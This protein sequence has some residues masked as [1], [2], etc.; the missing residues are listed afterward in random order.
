MTIKKSDIK[1]MQ[2]Q[3]MTDTSDGGGA[4]TGNEVLPDAHNTFFADISD[5][6]RAYGAVNMSKGFMQVTSDDADEYLGANM[7]LLANVT[8]PTVN[9]TLMTTGD[10]YDERKDAQNKIESYLTKSIKFNGMLLST[11]LEG[12]RVITLHTRTTEVE[13]DINSV[14]CLIQDENKATEF[15]QYVRLTKIT[16]EIREFTTLRGGEPYKFQ[17]AV[18]TCEISEP[19]AF[20]FDGSEATDIDG[21]Q[22]DTVVRETVV[23]NATN[24]YSSKGLENDA[25]VGELS[26]KVDGLYSQLV[27]SSR[28][29]I[30]MPDVYVNTMVNTF[31][32]GD[33]YLEFTSTT[34]FGKNTTLIVGWFTPSTLTI[35]SAI[36]DENG[37]LLYGDQI[38]GTVDYTSGTIYCGG[39]FPL[40]GN[41]KIRLKRAAPSVNAG[42][43]DSTEITAENQS[44][45][46]IKTFDTAP[47]QGS[48]KVDFMIG[49]KWYT[50]FD[51][52][53]GVLGNPELG[54][55]IINRETATLTLTLPALPDVGSSI[56]YSWGSD[57]STLYDQEA[58]TED[59]IQKM[60]GSIEYKTE[61]VHDSIE[62]HVDGVVI[63]GENGNGEIVKTPYGY[64]AQPNVIPK[65]ATQIR[66]KATSTETR[67]KSVK[68]STTDLEPLA[69]S[70]KVFVSAVS[71]GTGIIDLGRPN[72]ENHNIAIQY[73][74]TKQRLEAMIRNDEVFLGGEKIGSVG[75]NPLRI[76]LTP[77]VTTSIK[78]VTYK[79]W[80]D[81][82]GWFQSSKWKL[83]GTTTTERE[84]TLSVDSISFNYTS[85]P[86]N[87]V[88]V[89]F[90]FEKL[91][92]PLQIPTNGRFADG[93]TFSFGEQT[94][95][96]NGKTNE[97]DR[98]YSGVTTPAGYYST[99]KQR[100]E[101]TEWVEGAYRPENVSG[102][103]FFMA[104]IPT[105]QKVTYFTWR[106]PFAPIV[107]Q[108]LIINIPEIGI[109]TSDAQGK[110]SGNSVTGKVDY[111]RGVVQIITKGSMLV[112][113]GAANAVFF[114]A[115]KA[116]YS[117]VAYSFL[118][119]DS[120]I[121][122]IN[123]VRLPPDGRVPVYKKG[124][125]VLIH[126]TETEPQTGLAANTTINAVVRCG[127]IYLTNSDGDTID[128][129]LYS[130]DLDAGTLT[131]KSSFITQNCNLVY[132]F[133]DLALIVDLD[134]S[135]ILRLARPVSHNYTAGKATVSGVLIADTMGSRV[136]NLFEQYTWDSEWQ[137][138]PLGE[139]TNATFNDADYPLLVTNKG[140][141]T[142]RWALVFT[143]A[144]TFKVIG[145][146]VGQIAIGNTNETC[147]PI[148]PNTSVPYFT[149][150][151][152]G[153]GLGWAAGN[154]LRFNT[155]GAQFPFWLIRTIMQSDSTVTYD[156]FSLALRGNINREA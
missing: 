33:E 101:I 121:I 64:L 127:D 133:E 150:N 69:G 74:E 119:L 44:Y 83:N 118:P 16:R 66:V 105:P 49:G 54:T 113:N 35:D 91:I 30:A 50:I 8:D 92:I 24:Y 31:I 106:T 10:N 17:R 141:L 3:R 67:F 149:I 39:S 116:T 53:N 128:R 80:R 26:V 20:T 60:K 84:A 138:T 32:T 95:L 152:L 71:E 107:P 75:Y 2:A 114:D 29:E 18:L 7:A 87:D 124:D 34:P 148:N 57:P 48:L 77:N 102:G 62:F 12:Q 78:A 28:S 153:W 27:P 136:T 156:N 13:P 134:V 140:A 120:E 90:P 85:E 56:I 142:E 52:G 51:G 86:F 81:K 88:D 5:L 126:Q 61:A 103:A 42:F 40:E 89:T 63:D 145:E 98:F 132:R 19:L 72:G 25:K 129:N 9:I 144:T 125:L 37:S 73:V 70:L 15:S 41:L 97:I 147:A 46:V 55:G 21:V 117:A 11:Q 14:I 6:D 65:K 93:C 151:H 96:F 68:G 109:S 122:G 139:L 76:Y 1:L 154:V 137:D 100:L 143:S 47:S 104:Y 36:T 38:V 146:H 112:D 22:Q 79:Y 115:S 45:I 123:A 58:M 4:I 131:T 94:F 135:G 111:Q 108:S 155:L 59:R 82:G 43:T 110:I 130:V 23:A 99:P